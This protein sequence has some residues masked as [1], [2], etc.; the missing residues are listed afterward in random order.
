MIRGRF[1]AQDYLAV[2]IELDRERRRHRH[3]RSRRGVRARMEQTYAELERR[4]A[5]EPGVIAVTFADRLPGMQ[6]SVRRAEVETSP[7]SRARR[8]SEHLDVARVGPGFFEAFDRPILAGRGL[9]RW[10]PRGGRADGRS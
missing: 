4:V 9:P 7:G 8:R 3:A 2:R 6:P 5:Q 1:P 10:R